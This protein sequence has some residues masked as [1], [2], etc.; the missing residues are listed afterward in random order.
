MQCSRLARII[1]LL[2]YAKDE[3]ANEVQQSAA[4]LLGRSALSNSCKDAI[5]GQFGIVTLLKMLERS[6]LA[7]SS[8]E[9]VVRTLSILAVDNEM[10]QDHMR[11]QYAIPV[12]VKLLE[13][14]PFDGVTA[15]A[16]DALRALALNNEANKTAIREAWAVPLLV[17]LL[18]SEGNHYNDSVDEKHILA[19]V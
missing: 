10:N 16:A 8:K 14:M 18:G 4:L 7:R 3:Q 17:K 11:E 15:A 5:R 9:V 2:E 12:L 19:Q 13:T 6:G 1:K